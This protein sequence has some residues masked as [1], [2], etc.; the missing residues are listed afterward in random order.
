MRRILALAL[1]LCSATQVFG[2]NSKEL[3]ESVQILVEALREAKS[4]SV[5]AESVEDAAGLS[6][7]KASFFARLSA[8]TTLCGLYTLREFY[9]S[10]ELIE[11]ASQ[12]VPNTSP[13][14]WFQFG[15]RALWSH[16]NTTLIPSTRTVSDH[17]TRIILFN[18]ILLTAWAG[19]ECYPLIK[20]AFNHLMEV[21][22]EESDKQ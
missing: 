19:Y 13:F 12:L 2:K 17:K 15:S 14:W 8:V 1:L 10:L 18:A 5:Q 4:D 22:K 9:N 11:D 6:E 21:H 3:E 7:A 20:R 16:R